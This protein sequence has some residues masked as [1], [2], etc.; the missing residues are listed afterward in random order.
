MVQDRHVVFSALIHAAGSGPS[1]WRHPDV[2]PAKALD[3]EYYKTLAQVCE[4]ARFD[5]LFIADA[6]G[7]DPDNLETNT[8]WPQYQNVLEPLTLL[9]AV[10]ATTHNIGLGGTCSTSL[11]DPFSIARQF[12]SLDHLSKGRAAWNVVTSTTPFGPPNFGLAGHL[13]H[14]ERYV[15]A[16]ESL[17]VVQAYWDT[18]EDDAFVFNKKDAVNFDPAKFHLVDHKGKYFTA[19]GG[20]NIARSPQGQPVIIQAGASPV[21][22]DFAAE[23][24]EIVFGTGATLAEAAAFNT[25]LKSR[26]AKYGRKLSDVKVLAG[27]RAVVGRTEQEAKDKLYA[28]NAVLPFDAKLKFVSTEFNVDLGA[29]PLDQ[30]PSVDIIPK[31]PGNRGQGYFNILADMVR[32]QK[33][34][35]REIVLRYER[36]F[37]TF[38][39]TAVQVA[40]EMQRWIEGGAGD[41]FMLTFSYMPGSLEDFADM[42]VP[43]LQE[44]GLMRKEYFGK[45]LRENL[46]LDYPVNRHVKAVR[47]AAAICAPTS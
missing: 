35:V 34:T 5:L 21:G 9:A 30:I 10:A 42:V 3:F 16:K 36:G 38:T 26:V 15:K 6:V 4:K 31:T 28:L 18:W 14:D 44:R 25:D 8:K 17:E 2:D 32:S 20:L 22:K 46:N 23:K 39:G 40:D 33:M 41:G 11:T 19:R 37:D 47:Q 7:V 29:F 1:A 27:F 43:L 24:A 12:A 13:P 45:T